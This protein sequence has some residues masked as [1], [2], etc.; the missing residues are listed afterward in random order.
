MVYQKAQG[1]TEYLVL[2]AVVLII[3]LVAIALLGFFPGLSTDAKVTQSAS[4]WKAAR[5][6]AIIDHRVS[7]GDATLIMQNMDASGTLSVTGIGLGANATTL[8]S[9]TFAPGEIK[10]ISNLAAPT[11]S[12]GSVYDLAVVINFTSANGLTQSQMGGSKTLVG[13]YV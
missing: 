4:Y 7:G 1:S 9:I 13:K 10:N 11:G 2:L 3:A 6:F 5:P 12:A 8:S